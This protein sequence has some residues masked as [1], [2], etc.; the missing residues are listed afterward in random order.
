[1]PALLQAS[2]SSVPAGAVIFL[3]ST[4]RE[5]SAMNSFWIPLV[6]HHRKLFHARAFFLEWARPAIQVI[7][8]FL[9]ELLDERDGRHRR[10]VAKRAE[11]PAQHVLG[12]VLNVVDVL[13][14]AAPSMEAGK[15]L[16][17][18]VRSLA[19]GN[20]PSTTFVLVELHRAQSEFDDAVCVIEHH[21][22]ARAQH[23]TGLAD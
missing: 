12:K 2:I 16:L 21:N 20:A 22:P 15:R 3:P 13:L 4:V 19:A 11:C 18:P 7:F 10:R 1:M 17:Q 5:T 9:T 14:E 8:E 6:R 23:R